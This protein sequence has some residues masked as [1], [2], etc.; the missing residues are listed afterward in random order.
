MTHVDKTFALLKAK[1]V[2]YRKINKRKTRKAGEV[3][4]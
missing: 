3:Y 2:K 4:G 1:V